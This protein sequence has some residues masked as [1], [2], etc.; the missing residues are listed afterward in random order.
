MYLP[1]S[2]YRIQLQKG[3]NFCNLKEIIEYLHDLGISTIYAS[4]V[5]HAVKGSLHGYDN[6]D[7]L[8]LNPE[9]GTFEEWKSIQEEM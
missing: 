4:P 9:I 3:F 8:A 7:P 5:T 6:M 2:T 1:S